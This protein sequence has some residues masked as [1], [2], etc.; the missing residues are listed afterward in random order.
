[1]KKKSKKNNKPYHLLVYVA[2]CV[3]KIKRF[4]S[5]DKMGKFIDDFNKEYPDSDAADTG[6]WVDYAITNVEGD[7]HFF[8]DGMKVE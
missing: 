1:M 6:Y 2:N 8:T 3:T 7:V 5:T 4:E